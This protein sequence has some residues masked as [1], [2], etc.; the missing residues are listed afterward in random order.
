ME[1][2]QICPRPFSFPSKKAGGAKACRRQNLYFSFVNMLFC[3]LIPIPFGKISFA[4]GPIGCHRAKESCIRSL[5][6][7]QLWPASMVLFALYRAGRLAQKISDRTGTTDR[8]QRGGPIFAGQAWPAWKISK[9]KSGSPAS[10]R[11]P[12]FSSEETIKAESFPC[13]VSGLAGAPGNRTGTGRDSGWKNLGN[14]RS[15]FL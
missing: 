8:F 3:S 7:R 4:Q 13:P 6:L 2:R 5:W 1:P 9:K 10:N 14:R 12:R 11:E 15:M